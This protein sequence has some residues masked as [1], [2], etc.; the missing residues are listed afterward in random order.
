MKILLEGF[1]S[2]LEQEEQEERISKSKH[3]LI[4]IESEEQ[5]KRKK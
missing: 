2:R 1:N 3:G 5:I 4:E